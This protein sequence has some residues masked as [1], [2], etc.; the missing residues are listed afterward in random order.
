M[1][2]SMGQ[3]EGIEDAERLTTWAEEALRGDPHPL[4]PHYRM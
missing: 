4:L 3:L 1:S 2:F